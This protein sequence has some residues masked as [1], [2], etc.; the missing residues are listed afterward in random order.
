MDW[1]NSMK[2][3]ISYDENGKFRHDTTSVWTVSKNSWQFY[4]NYESE[5]DED[6]NALWSIRSVYDSYFDWTTLDKFEYTYEDGK[7]LLVRNFI[8]L[9]TLNQWKERQNDEFSYNEYGSEV[10]FLRKTWNS[11]DLVWVF[12]FKKENEYNSANQLISE[13]SYIWDVNSN[14]WIPSINIS[15][16]YDNNGNKKIENSYEWSIDSVDWLAITSSEYFYSIFTTNINNNFPE[17]QNIKVY[18]NPASETLTFETQNPETVFGK[19][20]NLK[21]ELVSCQL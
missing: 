9:S 10:L 2:K 18:P 7:R 16:E 6:G 15:Y 11:A 8:W 12:N 1:H 3:E 14:Q 19:L 21:G 20:Y 17:P 5:H 4:L 13:T